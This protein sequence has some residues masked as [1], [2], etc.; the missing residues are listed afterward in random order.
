MFQTQTQTQAFI[1]PARALGQ[2]QPWMQAQPQGQQAL[3]RAPGKADGA[4][5]VVADALAEGL[6][7]AMADHAPRTERRAT[8]AWPAVWPGQLGADLNA[9]LVSMLDEVDYGMLM[10]DAQG[11]VMYRN[12]AASLQLDAEH[13]LQLGP[14]GIRSLRPQDQVPLQD[15]LAAARRGLRKLLQLGEAE[16]RVS[17][18][19]VPLP[20][21][22]A[23]RPAATLLLLGKRRVCQQLS[24]LGFARLAGMTAAETRVLESLCAGVDPT[25]IAKRRSVKM[26]TVRTQINRIRE[27][28]GAASIREVVQ[29]VAMLPPMLSALRGGPG[30]GPG[31]GPVAGGLGLGP[32]P[33]GPTRLGPQALGAAA[34][35]WARP[36]HKR[37]PAV[38]LAA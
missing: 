37:A 30:P 6:L 15:A 8:A 19:V 10:V 16:H 24:V 5:G 25:D 18:A 14:Q 31:L 2:P 38:A 21:A 34:V 3:A 32:G 29:Q 12:H 23:N 27:K 17:V 35:P 4:V 22:S 36:A 33:V 7:D 26:S 20:S 9:S 13:P 28:C 11:Q 1:S